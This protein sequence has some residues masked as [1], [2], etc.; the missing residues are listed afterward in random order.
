MNKLILVSTC[1]NNKTARVPESLKLQN[2][3]SSIFDK[4]V[5]SWTNSLWQSSDKR[6]PARELYSGNHWGETLKAYANLQ[7]CEQVEP[8]LWVLSAGCGLVPADL[9]LPPYSA[10]FS[11]GPDGINELIWQPGW[12]AK[13]RSQYWWQGLNAGKP[14]DLPRTL[15]DVD[16]DPQTTWLIVLSKEYMPAVEQELFELISAGRQV[17]ICSAGSYT[18]Q[19]SLHPVLQSRLFALSEKFESYRQ[20]LH[21]SKV[22]LNANF[23]HW[24]TDE[25]LEDLASD[26]NGLLNKISQIDR[27]LPDPG[28][29]DVEEFIQR[30]KDAGSDLPADELRHLWNK[31]NRS[32]EPMTDEEVLAYIHQHYEPGVSSATKLLRKLRHEEMRS[33]EQKRFGALFKNYENRNQ[34]SLFDD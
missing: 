15:L 32:A 25:F 22:A 28:K 18:N 33:C 23:T 2:C 16:P 12:S 9:P 27:A 1:T 13:E 6:V 5:S 29:L 3:K 8:S 21:G 11:S 30:T 19:K 14:A 4:A 26:P 20:V 7:A 17:L 24:L 31:R 10:T 34:L